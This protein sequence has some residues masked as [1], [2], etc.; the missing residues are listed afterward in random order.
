MDVH[1]P[2]IRS[3]NMSQIKSKDTLPEMTVRKFLH[4]KGF[5]YR[6]HD[7]K[8]PG[9]PDIILPKY[10]TIIFVHGCFWHGHEGFKYE[11]KVDTPVENYPKKIID[12]IEIKTQKRRNKE[13]QQREIAMNTNINKEQSFFLFFR[14]KHS[15]NPDGKNL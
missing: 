1:E 14:K 9:T 8:L 7:K 10:N 5:R 3:Y 15:T 12:A 6:L 13:N 4:A 11:D 2:E